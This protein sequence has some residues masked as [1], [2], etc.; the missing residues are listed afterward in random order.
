[1]KE[2][3][4]KMKTAKSEMNHFQYEFGHGTTNKFF[5][6]TVPMIME[7]TKESTYKINMAAMR[8]IDPMPLPPMSMVKFNTRFFFVPMVDICPYYNEFDTQTP[9]SY[10][11]GKNNGQRNSTIPVKVPTIKSTQ[12]IDLFLGNIT[13]YSGDIVVNNGCIGSVTYKTTANLSDLPDNYD[14]R[15]YYKN[16]SNVT[17]GQIVFSLS[18]KGRTYMKLLK[19][20][21]YDF[22]LT[23]VY[24][25]EK[26]NGSTD[27]SLTHTNDFLDIEFSAMPLLAY[28]KVMLSYYQSS[29]FVNNTTRLADLNAL[30]H[31]DVPDYSL[32]LDD[33]E[34]IVEL[35]TYMT[36]END[37]F[38]T[39][40][41]NAIA[42][43]EF[44]NNGVDIEIKDETV[45]SN[46]SASAEGTHYN[47]TPT[48]KAHT[49]A[50]DISD[51]GL[52]LLR[53]LTNFMKR[54]Q[55]A[56]GR[57][58]DRMLA[59]YGVSLSDGY[60]RR[61]S[62][63]DSVTSVM[64]ITP[65]L[66][67]TSEQLGDYAGFGTSSVDGKNT[68][69]IVKT[70]ENSGFLIAIDTI[71]PEIFYSQGY[72]RI[73]RHVTKFDFLTPD[74]DAVSIQGTELGELYCTKQGIY[75]YQGANASDVRFGNK[76]RYAEYKERV[77]Y[78]TGDFNYNSI[79][80]D[81]DGYFT[82]RRF[83]IDQS[84]YLNNNDEIDLF[85]SHDFVSTMDR[86]QYSR[87]FYSN[88][89]NTD[90]IKSIFRF[91]IDCVAPMKPLYDEFNIDDEYGHNE[92][93]TSVGG[94]TMH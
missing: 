29:A 17:L 8:R 75:N 33:L 48:L 76:P 73:N 18:N 14:F 68:T 56:G 23:N 63:I 84:Q 82:D 47:G 53:R 15:L 93:K 21:G 74:F 13:K 79:N 43:N 57:M 1:M 52:K 87:I 41:V 77:S 86:K 65:V 81:V 78:L 7:L 10:Q 36:Y 30:C 51:T 35:C 42:G 83:S 4:V 60:S 19:Q 11:Y 94:Q 2:T 90:Y 26:A 22:D 54:H 49:D 25:K 72:S 59:E 40:F 62:Y 85:M 31:I 64:N 16:T 38:T 55:I 28:L 32:T 69:I 71:C 20:L 91:F 12:L 3:K 50:G 44:V 46:N 24:I 89:A 9:Y 61:T 67:T 92:V 6:P 37:Y 80:A 5:E 34:K 39:N 58:V 66:N 27:N 88:K 45:D 70:K